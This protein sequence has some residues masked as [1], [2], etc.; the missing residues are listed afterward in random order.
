MILSDRLQVIA[1]RITKGETMADIGTDHGFL[2]LYLWENK[3]CPKIIMADISEGSLKKAEDNCRLFYP[4]E[5]KAGDFDL[6]L[7]NGIGVLKKGEI[8]SVVIAGMGGLLMCKI[9]GDDIDKTRSFKKLI[10]QPRNNPGRL[11]HFLITNGFEIADETLVREGKYIC[12]IITAIPANKSKDISYGAIFDYPDYLVK[13]KN[14][15]T[16][17]YLLRNLKKE[18]NTLTGIKTGHKTD[19][20]A[21]NYTQSKINQIKKLLSKIGG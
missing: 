3:I 4:M 20:E 8:D 1:D 13:F 15:L 14:P 17:E 5:L 21:L 11:R 18:E 19:Y 16:E 6:R 2:P 9:L 10:M 12:E 7:G